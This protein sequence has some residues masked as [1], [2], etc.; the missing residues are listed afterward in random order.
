MCFEQSFLGTVKRKA[1]PLWFVFLKKIQDFNHVN[2]T[3]H[4]SIILKGYALTA[5]AVENL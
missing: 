2:S 3:K 1:N 4:Y 5:S